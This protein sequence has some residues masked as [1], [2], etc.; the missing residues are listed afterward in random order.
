[1]LKKEIL[2]LQNHEIELLRICAK[3]EERKKTIKELKKELSKIERGIKDTEEKLNSKKTQLDSVKKFIS[4]KEKELEELKKLK[5]KAESKAE[6]KKLLREIAKCED[7]IIKAS[8]ELANLE[9]EVEVLKEGYKRVLELSSPR[10]KEINEN[11]EE[12]EKEIQLL[13]KKKLKVEEKIA[14]LKELVGSDEI[15]RFEEYKKKFNGLVFA[16]VSSGSCEGCGIKFSNVEFKELVKNMV[17]GRTK[18]PYC[19]RFVYLS[20]NKS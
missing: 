11:I 19:G 16:D 8:Q 1:M 6:F 13:E 2:E 18:C 15:Q 12:I 10:K 20:K 4:K 14:E 9:A 5:E 7:E 17:P 3:I